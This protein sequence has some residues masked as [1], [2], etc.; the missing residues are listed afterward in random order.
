MKVDK[1]FAMRAATYTPWF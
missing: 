1:I